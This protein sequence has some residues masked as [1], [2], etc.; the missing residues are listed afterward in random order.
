MWTVLLCLTLESVACPSPDLNRPRARAL[1]Y[2]Y[3]DGDIEVSASSV[4]GARIAA[5]RLR[6]RRSHTVRVDV[7]G[8]YLLPSS[9]SDY[10]RLGI[11]LVQAGNP[12]T[13][14][15]LAADQERELTVLSV[16][17][18]VGRSTPSSHMRYRLARNLA[19]HSTRRVLNAWRRHPT[20][21]P[22]LVQTAVWRRRPPRSRNSDTAED[23]ERDPAVNWGDAGAR[24][25]ARG[26]AEVTPLGGRFYARTDDGWV[27][28][29]TADDDWRMVPGTVTDLWGSSTYLFSIRGALSKQGNGQIR[30]AL[31][32]LDPST[33][34]W[35]DTPVRVEPSLLEKGRLE[36]VARTGK[37]A[38]ARGEKNEVLRLGTRSSEVIIPEAAILDVEPRGLCRWVSSHEPTVLRSLEPGSPQEGAYEHSAPIIAI[39]RAEREL[40]ILDANRSMWRLTT[41][42][43][44]RLRRNVA[45]IQGIGDQLLVSS[46][47]RAGEA[48]VGELLLYR[49]GTRRTRMRFPAGPHGRY[50]RD[51]FD[52]ALYCLT[53]DLEILRYVGAPKAWR[54]VA[55][56]SVRAQP[57]S[58]SP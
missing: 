23:D 40:Y 3:R 1:A 36:W 27:H 35:I 19:P 42:E 38:I 52:D 37:Y 57:K 12:D 58:A 41:A 4:S 25:S 14:I 47:P 13:T 28:M 7:N 26:I 50:C 9:S 30:P 24:M 51:P 45:T 29:R 46:L 18:D 54:D 10:Q 55:D 20:V 6:N 17:L 21:D 44:Q 49:G 5:L 31:S 34:G 56:V 22:S 11:G 53:G 8:S 32:R 33:L 39:A 48:R 15:T 2:A 43:P 16:C